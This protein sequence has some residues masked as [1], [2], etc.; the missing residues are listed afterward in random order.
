MATKSITLH[1]HRYRLLSAKTQF[2]ER[3][4][5]SYYES[6]DVDLDDVY[7]HYSHAKARAMDYCRQREIE[8][9][10]YNGRIVG[11][12]SMCF[13]YAFTTYQDGNIYLVYITKD[14]DSAFFLKKVV[15]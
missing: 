12:N 5:N 7:G 10:S 11:H 14:H 13:S 3:I 1:G 4:I 6:S 9:D 15:D 8:C 2:A